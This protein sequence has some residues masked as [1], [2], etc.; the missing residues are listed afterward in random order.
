MKARTM[1]R[2]KKKERIDPLEAHRSP[3]ILVEQTFYLDEDCDVLSKLRN[4]KRLNER[5]RPRKR[6]D[7]KT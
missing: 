5:F 1:G 7:W 6:S 2:T 3:A 4:P